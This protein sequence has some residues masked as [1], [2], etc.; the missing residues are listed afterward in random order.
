MEAIGLLE[1]EGNVA[2][3]VAVDAMMKAATVKFL[4]WEQ[5]LGGRLV[6]IVVQGEVSAV[7]ASIEAGRRTAIRPVAASAII[8]NP[9]S[10]VM[11]AIL[12]S[13]DRQHFNF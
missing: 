1:I 8:A 4:T 11:R 6:T 5:K 9:H 7:E 12:T 2:A 13:M 3:V 10:E